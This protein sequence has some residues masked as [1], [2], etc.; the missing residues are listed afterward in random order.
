MIDLDRIPREIYFQ[1]VELM[2]RKEAESFIK[3]KH[4]NFLAITHKIIYLRLKKFFKKKP[5]IFLLVFA[6]ILAS[7]VLFYL[8]P[9]L[10]I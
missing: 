2:G 7:I 10:A 6:I 9:F 1:L 4:Y 5:R 3:K 8:S